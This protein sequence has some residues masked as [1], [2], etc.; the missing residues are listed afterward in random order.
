MPRV[1]Q[2]MSSCHVRVLQQNHFGPWGLSGCPISSR[3]P[4]FCDDLMVN[5]TFPYSSCYLFWR[6]LPFSVVRNWWNPWFW[7]LN[8]QANQSPIKMAQAFGH[9]VQHSLLQNSKILGDESV[10]A[11]A[12]SDPGKKL[13]L[14]LINLGAQTDLDQRC[15]YIYIHIN[16]FVC[17]CLCV[18]TYSTRAI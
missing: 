7:R 16:V 17:V 1:H 3:L 5:H 14:L 15:V 6:S 4:R 9:C 10:A 18:C 12:A 8:S 2:K 11:L 13:E